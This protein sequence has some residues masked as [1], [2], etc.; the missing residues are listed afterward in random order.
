MEESNFP[1]LK[2]AEQQGKV[3][4]VETNVKLD[5]II[6]NYEKL[7]DFENKLGFFST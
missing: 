3:T 4:L 1:R 2:R 5:K 7:A 6:K